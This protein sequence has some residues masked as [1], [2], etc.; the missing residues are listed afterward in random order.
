[1]KDKITVE[2]SARTIVFTVLFILFVYFIG[3]IR[4][5]LFSIFIAFIFRSALLPIVLRLKRWHF[6]QTFAA[7]VVFFSFIAVFAGFLLFVFPPLV[8]E[9][10]NFLRTIP[11]YLELI[12]PGQNYEFN[13]DSSLNL[14]PNVTSS[15]FT[16]I[17]SLFS[18][19]FFIIMTLFLSL[20]FLI[21]ENFVRDLLINFVS[22]DQVVWIVEIT[23]K[24]ERRLAAWLWGELFLMLVI[25]VFTYIGLRLLGVKYA[26]S[27]AVLAGLLEVVPNVGPVLSLIPAF[28]IS[29]STSYLQAVSV[30]ALYFVIQQLENTLIVPLV[31]KKAVGINPIVTLIGLVIGGR[32]GGILGIVLSIPAILFLETIIVEVLKRKTEST[33]Y[34]EI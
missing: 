5:I 11:D 27:L 32:L 9:T 28:L 2:I 34:K 8:I 14:L 12:F 29:L 15:V 1:M 4:D 18:N 24:V 26:L 19:T 30:A 3:L 10:S 6:P 33:S 13:L 20:Y 22:D 7:V 31:M 21:Q 23:K 17:G 25:G 16:L